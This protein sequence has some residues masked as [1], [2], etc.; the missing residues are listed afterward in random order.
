MAENLEYLVRILGKHTTV[1]NA[2]PTTLEFQIILG[3]NEIYPASYLVSFTK[4]LRTV[5][6]LEGCSD[7]QGTCAKVKDKEQSKICKQ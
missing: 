6:S 3:R 4:F 2:E 5:S 7:S 1:W